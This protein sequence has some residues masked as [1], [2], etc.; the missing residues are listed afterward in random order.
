MNAVKDLVACMQLL[1]KKKQLDLRGT[2]GLH[3]AFE[4]EIDFP[5]LRI[6]ITELERNLIR[7]SCIHGLV[8]GFTHHQ[9]NIY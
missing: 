8:L 1:M 9:G 2:S 4:L 3:R 5:I 6:L 7:T